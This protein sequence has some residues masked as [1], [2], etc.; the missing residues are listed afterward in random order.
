MK[1]LKIVLTS[2]L[3]FGLYYSYSQNIIEAEYFF[4][5]DPGIGSAT[6]LNLSPGDT[7]DLSFTLPTSTLTEGFHTFHIRY[8]NDI[9]GWG[10]YQS[11]TFHIQGDKM[12]DPD[13]K[14]LHAE[15]FFDSV[16]ATGTGFPIS[17]TPGDSTIFTEIVST[18][19]LSPGFHTIYIRFQNDSSLWG[20]YQG[21]KFYMQSDQAV[22]SNAQMIDAEYFIDSEPGPGNGV[23]FSINPGDSTEFTAKFPTDTLSV[24]FHDFYIRV[25][26]DSLRW[27]FYRSGKFYVQDDPTPPPATQLVGAEYFIDN[28]PGFGNG[29]PIPMIPSDSLNV[30]LKFGSDGIDTGYHYVYARVLSSNDIW[31]IYGRDTFLIR[32]CTYPQANF[33][34]SNVCFGDTA[35]FI[36]QS[37]NVDSAAVYEWDIDNDGNIDYTTVGNIAHLYTSPGTYN[38]RLRVLNSGLCPDAII[39]PVTILSPDVYIGNDTSICDCASITLDAGSGYNSYVWSNNEITRTINVIPLV[40]TNYSV[41]VTDHLGCPGSDDIFVNTYA[42]PGFTVNAGVLLQGAYSGSG[43]MDTQL[44]SILPLAQPYNVD[45]WQYSGGEMLTSIPP[46]MVDWI[47]IELRSGSDYSRIM[48]RRAGILMNNGDILETDLSGGLVF[49]CIDVGSYYVVVRHRNHLPVMSANSINMPF[50]GTMDFK[51]VVNNPPFG[52]L[53]EALIEMEPDHWGIISGDVMQDYNL[54]YSGPDNDRALVLQK[55]VNVS[56]SNSITTTIN[57]YY[58]EDMNM[59]GTV[60]YSG[61]GNDPSIIIQ[62]LGTLTGSASIT[63]IFTISVP[64]GNP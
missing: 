9:D 43:T 61:P 35:Y 41:T 22:S 29:I 57:G 63:T 21:R 60:K 48:D 2:L 30:Q 40:P 47:L 50:S 31:S 20:M 11:R 53:T 8:K 14:I 28:D 32:S 27:G 6:T 52:N 25:R 10:M 42:C 15:Y 38:V 33:S 34:V 51:N 39:K 44:N 3:M 16:P 19:G 23:N 13:P 56:G 49:N 62:N 18:A 7:S 5:T 17:I 45:P 59:D 1:K 36:D 24:G 26:N 46:Q 55:L 64:Q 58:R 37:T 4:D 54:K 12:I